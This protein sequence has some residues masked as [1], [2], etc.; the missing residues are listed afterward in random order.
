MNLLFLFPSNPSPDPAQCGKPTA[1]G[2]PSN[3]IS[4]QPLFCTDAIG[5][6]TGC[7]GVNLQQTKGG[8]KSLRNVYLTDGRYKKISFC[9]Q[10]NSKIFFC[11]SSWQ[12]LSC[13]CRE[14]IVVSLWNQ[15]AN[16]FDAEHY[17]EMAGRGP[18]VLFVGM[19]C[20]IFEGICF[21]LHHSFP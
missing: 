6:F 5:V 11:F 16:S 10:S 13:S 8:T 21:L 2:T 14:T 1:L 4:M 3:T 15:H 19:T 20:R 9:I 18:V 7:S 12:V 17:M